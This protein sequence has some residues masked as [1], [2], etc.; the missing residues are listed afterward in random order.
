MNE[1]TP[2]T[3]DPSASWHPA[4]EA[5]GA[6][7][8]A[9]ERTIKRPLPPEP[10]ASRP[11]DDSPA[12]HVA[13]QLFEDYLRRGPQLRS[14]SLTD[15]RPADPRSSQSLAG[16]VHR[17]EATSSCG[18]PDSGPP[19][20]RLP[21]LGDQLFGF[22]LRHELGRGSFARVF[23]AEEVELAGRPVVL[24]VSAIEGTEPQMLAQLQH[25][26]IVPV[27]SVHESARVG[28]RALCMPYFGGSSLSQ[29]LRKLWEHSPRP[30]RGEELVRALE[31]VAAPAPVGAG[32]KP[33]PTDPTDGPESASGAALPGQTPREVLARLIPSCGDLLPSP[34]GIAEV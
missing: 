24:K 4:P 30:A 27:Y 13:S 14:D 21:N 31:A 17:H 34:D 19:R 28:L 20:P 26:H 8:S 18:G 33:A 22:C 3:G 6:P 15:D 29:V 25:T 2:G 7:G 9:L 5:H 10:S 23:V 16:L 1:S 11:G 32:L 12:R